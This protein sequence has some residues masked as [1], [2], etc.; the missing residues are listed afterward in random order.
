[1]VNGGKEMSENAKMVIW[2]IIAMADTFYIIYK[3]MH[4]KE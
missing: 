1:M 4:K 2:I 3:D